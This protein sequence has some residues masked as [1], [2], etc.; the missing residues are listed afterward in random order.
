MNSFKSNEHNFEL[1]MVI[2]W[3]PMKLIKT[4]V[5]WLNLGCLKISLA[6]AF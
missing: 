4:G 1:N 6:A 5:I 2:D 3:E